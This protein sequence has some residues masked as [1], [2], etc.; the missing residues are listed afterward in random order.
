MAANQAA[1]A[2]VRGRAGSGWRM[3]SPLRLR[4]IKAMLFVA[5]L[6]PLARLVT[7]GVADARGLE[8]AGPLTLGANPI[9]LVTRSTGTWTLVFLC[10]TLAVTPLRRLTGWHW[11]VKLRRMIGLF[12]FFYAALHF[13]TYFWFDQ[14]FDFSAI[15]ADVVKRPFITVG[16]L[17]FVLLVP[18]ALTSTDGMIRRLGR[19]WSTLHMAIYPIVTLGVLHYW[20][21]VKRDVT[22]PAIYAAIIAVLL[23]F[24][25]AWRVRTRGAAGPQPSR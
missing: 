18:L 19:R 8:W 7:A 24:R 1:T 11:L 5:F 23:G 2:A 21:L 20:W 22:Q 16:F 15:V 3:P 25:L 17:A 10:A 12:A 4:A 13:V 14:W 6:L 9:E